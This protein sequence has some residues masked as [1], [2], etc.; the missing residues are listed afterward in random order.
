MTE[1][2]PRGVQSL[3]TS[4]ARFFSWFLAFLLLQYFPT[5]VR[6]LEFHTCMFIFAAVIILT[7][8]IVV[9]FCVPEASIRDI[10]TGKEVEKNQVK[11]VEKVDELLQVD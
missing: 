3:V 11:T 2:V 5:A 9:V 4:I 1:V 7:G 6:I 8:T 10:E